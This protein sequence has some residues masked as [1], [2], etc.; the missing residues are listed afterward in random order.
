MHLPISGAGGQALVLAP[1]P[2]MPPTCQDIIKEPGLAQAGGP[3]WAPSL[4]TKSAPWGWGL[5][6]LAALGET[7]TTLR[8]GR[9][10]GGETREAGHPAKCT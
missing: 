4:I 5:Q 10:V 7:G 9:G 3:L 8:P 6:P 1:S 2:N